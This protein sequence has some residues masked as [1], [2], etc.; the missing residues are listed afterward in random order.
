MD[1]TGQKLSPADARDCAAWILS[2]LATRPPSKTKHQQHALRGKHICKQPPP[3]YCRGSDRTECVYV[4]V[5]IL[6]RSGQKKKQAYCEVDT[7][8]G[9]LLGKSRRGKPRI[10]GIR[11]EAAKLK[12]IAS[13]ARSFQKIHPDAETLVDCRTDRF[14][15]LRRAGILRGSSYA[16]NSGQ[17]MHEFW[18]ESVASLFDSVFGIGR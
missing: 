4:A 3:G 7:L 18:R 9:H 12:T 5:R 1:S 2:D 11:D 14:L 16:E 15:M 13:L 17:K 6:E 8:A 10:V